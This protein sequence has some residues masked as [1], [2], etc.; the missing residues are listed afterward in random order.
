M[1]K[2]H[3][4]K[5]PKPRIDD[6]C[7]GPLKVLDVAGNHC[8]SVNKGCR[9]NQSVDFIAAIGDVKMGASHRVATTSS[10]AMMRPANS[11]RTWL[12]SQVRN[13]APCRASRRCTPRIPRSNSR[14]V[15]GERK[16]EAA[17][18]RLTQATTLASAL[19][20]ASENMVISGFTTGF[21]YGTSSFTSG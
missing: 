8:Q 18:S 21:C 1:F 7:A 10:T 20:S 15:I 17:S 12:S 4:A 9:R 14:M 6:D 2:L 19:P 5:S 13:R 3:S 11:G 16:K